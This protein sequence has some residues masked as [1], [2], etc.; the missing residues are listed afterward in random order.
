LLIKKERLL[1]PIGAAFPI[2]EEMILHGR[3]QGGGGESLSISNPNKADPLG[4][5]G[6]MARGESLAFA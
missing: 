2:P 5:G 1:I 3:E 4:E 6:D